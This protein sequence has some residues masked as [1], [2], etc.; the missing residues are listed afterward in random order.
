MSESEKQHNHRSLS[1]LMSFVICGLFMLL[2][3][4]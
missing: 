4:E 2:V 1:L 3:G